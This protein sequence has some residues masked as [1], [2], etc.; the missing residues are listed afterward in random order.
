MATQRALDE[1]YMRCATAISQL[2]QAR[3][4][5][6]GAIIVSATGHHIIA[7]GFNGTPAGFDNN[8]EKIVYHFDNGNRHF[9]KDQAWV[10]QFCTRNHE[11]ILTTA[12]GINLEEG[13]ETL[14]EVIHAEA[15]AL[16]K[17]ARS[18]NNSDGGTLYCTLS[19]CFDCAKQIIQAGIKRVVYQ[20]QYPYAGHSG[21]IRLMG[22]E[23]LHKANI[24]VIQLCL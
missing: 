22:L 3:R 16:S 8:C 4:K 7:E 21:P 17:V 14:P 5:K 1:A 13:L 15:N 18:T 24:E 20:E 12:N 23:L 11:G 2:S 10:D 6:V 19:P 9:I